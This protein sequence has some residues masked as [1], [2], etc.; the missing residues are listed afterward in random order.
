MSED[1]LPPVPPLQRVWTRKEVAASFQISERHLADL[2]KQH[3]VPILRAGAAVRYDKVAFDFLT[4]ACRAPEHRRANRDHQPM[5]GSDAT[6]SSQAALDREIARARKLISAMKDAWASA[7]MRGS[8]PLSAGSGRRLDR[9]QRA[10]DAITD[11]NRRALEGGR[12]R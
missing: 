5:A 2:E 3:A 4:D 8:S 1:R 6:L 11:R 12:K 7:E 10:L 9:T